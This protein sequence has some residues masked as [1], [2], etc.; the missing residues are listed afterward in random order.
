MNFQVVNLR[1]YRSGGNGD[2]YLGQRSDTGE[3]VVV[4]FCWLSVRPGTFTSFGAAVWARIASIALGPKLPTCVAT[5]A[6]IH[7]LRRAKQPLLSPSIVTTVTCLASP[8]G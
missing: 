6:S 5:S 2:L 4:K 7:L 3:W 1:M 8:T